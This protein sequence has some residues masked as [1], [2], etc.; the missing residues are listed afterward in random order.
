[1]NKPNNGDVQ[2]VTRLG[3][4]NVIMERQG[5]SIDR[6]VQWNYSPSDELDHEDGHD[7]GKDGSAAHWLYIEHKVDVESD[8]YLSDGSI[9]TIWTND[10]VYFPMQGDGR[11]TIGSA[12]R[13]PQKHITFIK[14]QAAGEADDN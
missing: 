1:M 12:P 7:V 3:V 9:W 13:N 2:M 14:W 11:E 5:D 8:S 10:W 6:I 4:L